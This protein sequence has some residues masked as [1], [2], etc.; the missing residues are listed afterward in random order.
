MFNFI[1]IFIR[2]YSIKLIDIRNSK[3]IYTLDSNII[4]N[5]CECPLSLTIDKK[6]FATGSTKGD[7]YIFNTETGEL[8][9][10]IDNKSKCITSIQWR[11]YHSQIYVG[12]IT[13]M[14]TIWGH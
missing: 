8:A 9:D 6:Y 2:D 14:L 11:P 3:E 13:G 4:P 10:K 5:Y 7:I 12:D 1:I